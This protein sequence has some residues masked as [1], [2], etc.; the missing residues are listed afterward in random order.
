M[1][2]LTK[3]NWQEPVAYSTTFLSILIGLELGVEFD[4]AWLGRAGS[5]VVVIGILLASSRKLDL[6]RR[7]VQ[8]LNDQWFDKAAEK[9]LGQLEGDGLAVSEE[10]KVKLL[11]RMRVEITKDFDD[12]IDHRTQIFKRHE[13]VIVIIGTLLNGCG[14]WLLRS[15]C[16]LAHLC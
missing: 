9:S 3:F 8:K 10:V 6:L 4:P 15:S 1:G 7:H 16:A 13:V 14:E 2:N 5:I 12:E 11:T